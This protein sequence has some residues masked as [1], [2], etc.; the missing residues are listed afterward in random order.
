MSGF[1]L[2]IFL[3]GLTALLAGMPLIKGA[4][5]ITVHELDTVHLVDALMR[6]AEGQVPHV[7]FMTPIGILSFLPI[8]VPMGWGAGVGEALLWGQALLAVALL[9]A[10][11]WVALSRFPGGPGYLFGALI[12]VTVTALIFSTSLPDISISLHYNRWCWA[13]AFVAIALAVV[14]PTGPRRPILDGCLLGL[15]M[16][17]LA[18]M[19]VT[20]FAALAIPLTAALLLRRDLVALAVTAF[21]GLAVAGLVTA[22]FGFDY[23]LAYLGDLLAVAG[24]DVRPGHIA[25]GDLVASPRYLGASAAALAAVVLL[26][27]SGGQTEGLLLLLLLPAFVYITSENY[28]TDPFWLVL[29]GVLLLRWAPA[30]G[31][32][33]GLGWDL[34]KAAHLI[35]AV[36]FAF[37]TPLLV[38][39]TLSPMRNLGAEAAQFVP[40]IPGGPP[41]DSLLL[42]GERVDAVTATTTLV[43][44]GSGRGAALAGPEEAP[45]VTTVQGEALP[46][47][48]ITFG[49]PPL[50]ESIASYVAGQVPSDAIVVTADNVSG[51][52][53]YSDL[54]PLPRGAPWYYG[55]PQGFEAAE[56]FVVPLCAFELTARRLAIEAME[57]IGATLEE[58]GRTDQLILF[59]VDHAA[60]G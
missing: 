8:V 46:D 36:A 9:P 4:L 19:K 24:S 12:V 56:F 16:A 6:M 43:E 21:T 15:L 51:L 39:M 37:S 3:A 29:M 13:I 30:A 25:L 55:G 52:W 34:R 31:T 26:R 45:K 17:A 18:L 59:R 7:D 32:L 40:M 28:R 2:G 35:V 38:N 44:A 14:E 11:W 57:G 23:W 60:R 1:R 50:M 5:Y 48:R 58:V 33:N 54:P 41:H 47:C 22:V 53:L 27:Q 10:I 20:Y 42:P 49:A